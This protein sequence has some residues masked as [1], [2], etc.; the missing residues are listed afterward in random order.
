[1]LFQ[2]QTAIDNSV[3]DGREVKAVEN[4]VPRFCKYPLCISPSTHNTSQECNHRLCTLY[5]ETMICL[6]LSF[7][8]QTTVIEIMYES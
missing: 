8:L 7:I 2:F 1:M 3:T 5:F 6:K 4:R